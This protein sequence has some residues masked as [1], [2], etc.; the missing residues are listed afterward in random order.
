[1]LWLVLMACRDKEP[2]VVDRD[3]GVWETTVD[4][5]LFIDTA[6]TNVPTD[7]TGK[8]ADDT[9]APTPEAE[10][11]GL[12]LYPDGVTVHPGATFSL[13]AVGVWDDGSSSD[14]IGDY[15]SSDEKIA[16]IDKEGVV[17]A[18]SAGA[19]TLSAAWGK[20]SDDVTLTVADDGVLTITVVNAATGAPIENAKVKLYEEDTLYTNA[21]GQ[22]SVT[23]KDGGPVVISAYLSDYVPA[24]IWQTVSRNIVLP[25]HPSSAFEARGTATGTVNFDSVDSGE[26][27]DIVMGMVI[28]NM[29]HGPLMLDPDDLLAEDRTVSLYGID[30]DVPSNLVLKNHA[31]DFEATVIAGESALWTIAGAMPISEVTSGLNGTTEAIALLRD[32]IDDMVWGWADAGS[33]DGGS[34]TSVGIAPAVS[35]TEEAEVIVPDLSIGF[36]GSEDPLVMV[37]ESLPEEGV[38]VTGLGLGLG[39]VE[40]QTAN[41]TLTDSTGQVAMAIAQVGGLGTGGAVAATWGT[42]VDGVATLPAFQDIPEVESFEPTTHEFSLYSDTRAALVRVLIEGADGT[43]RLLYLTG[44]AH[45]G[46]LPNPGF[47]MGYGNTTW[48]ILALEHSEDTLE[49]RLAT[50]N[51]LTPQIALTAQTAARVGSRFEAPPPK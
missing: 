21:S 50:G 10:V 19:V 2:D 8:G 1:M 47:P 45:A 44:G 17:T 15:T 20:I 49:G 11:V 37:G 13:R 48:T 30:A 40:V 39:E 23:V 43:H 6:D 28:P 26:V 29:P 42:V 7:D 14:L 46:T 36:N 41:H 24:T 22:T 4:T 9:G 31:E 32:H 12:T 34:S 3:P 5:G 35:F 33:V 27:T 51:I 16:T 25:L 18:H 38:V